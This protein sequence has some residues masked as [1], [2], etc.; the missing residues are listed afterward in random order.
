[1]L[2][3]IKLVLG[4]TDTSKDGLIQ[5]YINATVKKI[6][7]YTNRIELPEALESVV[8]E[9]VIPKMKASLSGSSTTSN[10]K[11]EKIGDYEIQYNTDSNSNNELSPYLDILDKFIIKKVR[12][13]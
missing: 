1:M 5:Y 8:E 6:L 13:Y 3:N 2:D 11:S 4:I 9:I 12:T 10:V 7:A